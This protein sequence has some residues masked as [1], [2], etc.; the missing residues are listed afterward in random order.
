VS[1]GTAWSSRVAES[2][3]S[4]LFPSDCRLCGEP[5]LN[6]SRLPVCPDCVAGVHSIRGKVCSICGERVL[7]SY[8]EADAEGQRQCPVC[9]RVERP[10]AQAVAY[11]SYDGG[12][13]ELIHLLK[14]NGVR[15]AAAVLGRML[16]EAL[17]ALEPAF[18][19]ARFARGMFD[20]ARVL[21]I[22]VPL[23]KS[24]RRQRG[25]N[26]S[27]LIARSALKL[28][29]LSERLQLAPGLLLRT[30][31][32][33]SQIGLTSHQRREN[34]RGAFAVTRAAEVTGRDLL[35]VD[36]VYTTG[37]TA[38]ECARVLRRAGARNVWVAT[39]ARTLKLTSNYAEFRPDELES[40]ENPVPMAKAAG[41]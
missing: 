33:K 36:D 35:L 23:H 8:A 19:Q 41:G 4:V 14:Y 30:R 38:T 32:T 16:A 6:I 22:A 40:E 5:L 11:G 29:S 15:P 20:D 21:V 31:D 12:L 34:L 3:F 28:H 27:E 25:F 26:Q 37:T 18:E 10:F 13:R 7:S 24:K 2:L 9:R 39:V 17:T 1:C